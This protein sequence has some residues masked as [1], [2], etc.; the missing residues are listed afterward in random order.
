MKRHAD[1]WWNDAEEK[2]RRECLITKWSSV[3]SGRRGV[4][5]LDGQTP[6]KDHLPTSFALLAPQWS[7]WQ[8]PPPLSKSPHSSFK[9]VCDPILPGCWARAQDTDSC[10]TGPLA[11]PP[12]KKAKGPLS[13][14]TLKTSVNARLKEHC[15]N[16]AAGTHP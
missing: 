8:P 16:G 3:G 14:L 6:R 1:E 9:P 13:W 11:L 10:H 7:F 5:L 12:C 2:E 4:Q 15:N